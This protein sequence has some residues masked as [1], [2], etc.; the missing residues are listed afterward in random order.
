MI[1]PFANLGKW[2][3]L[4]RGCGALLFLAFLSAFAPGGN[5][6]DVP[7]AVRKAV[8]RRQEMVAKADEAALR[9]Q[10]MLADKDYA[11][12]VSEL[13]KALDLLPEAP[14]VESRRVEYTQQFADGSVLLARQRA[15]EGQYTEAMQIIE[16]V[17]DPAIDPENLEARR[18]LEDLND[19]EIYPQAITPEHIARVKRVE[20]AL[21]EASSHIRIG[22]YDGAERRYHEALNYD[23]YNSA[24]RR[25]L[26]DVEKHRRIYYDTAYDQTR[27]TFLRQVEEQWELKPPRF[28]VDPPGETAG[29]TLTQDGIGYINEK[30]KNIIIPEIEFAQTPFADAIEFL[31]EKS[32]EL[33]D[34]EPD[35]A[36]KGVNI[37]DPP[38]SGGAAAAP[39]APTGGVP[40][41][42]DPTAPAASMGG[43]AGST[44]LIDLK[45][46]QI[47]LVDALR[48][49]TE[50]ARL[51]FKVEPNA[52]KIIPLT[53]QN[54]DLATKV[55]RVPPSFLTAGASGGGGGGAQLSGDPFAN[56][57][58]TP[59]AGAA[60]LQPK[61]SAKEVLEGVGVT[62]PPDSSA[63]YNAT[64]SQLIVRNTQ[65][66]LDLVEAYVDS[67]KEDVQK[68]IFITSKFVEIG[69][70][71]D[72]TF[73]FD[74]L[75]GKANVP[76]SDRVFM[77]GG[78]IGS[79]RGQQQAQDWSFV[80]PIS[81]QP[82]GGDP[83][84]SGLRSGALA[85]NRN[86][87]DAL[88]TNTIA[89]QSTLAPAILSMAGVFTDPQ[90]Q[91]VLRAISQSKGTDLM[92]APSVVA[93]SGQIAKLEVIR[94]F[95]Y[96]TE[97]D[98]P[99]IPQQFGNQG[100][101]QQGGGIAPSVQSF[102]VTPAN[103]T[104]FETRNV[105]VT[106]QATPTIGPD[107]FTIDLRLEP[108][109]VEF[110]GFINYGSPIYTG[111]TA[112]G[113]PVQV[114]LTENRIEMPVFAKRSVATD[115]TI[116]DGQTVAVGG[117][118]REDIQHVEDKLPILGDLPVA[119]FLFRSKSEVHAKRN[120]TIFVTARLIDPSG[121][122]I[123]ESVDE[124]VAPV[125]IPG[126]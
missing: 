35:P 103:P 87:V 45:V 40:G 96:P 83:L 57:G 124:P 38:S 5:A 61:R 90:F 53:E 55:F 112:A 32:R 25:G 111:G 114:L 58:S 99:E 64:N 91:V 15:E 113:Q 110:E 17:L 71:N 74:W 118:I 67:L 116:W 37:I 119:G 2:Q 115:V 12:A 93:R 120:L 108:E 36:K 60:G 56:L 107:G 122:P 22:D 125:K 8:A 69:Q 101:G 34:L 105:G 28:S 84:T 47:P 1:R 76:G 29:P 62:F 80:E 85:V 43:G 11:G 16:A 117:L 66:N 109:V 97:Y 123:N 23:P 42:D 54:A 24:A 65:A 98:P 94:E 20:T 19:P 59:A 82:F 104:A 88:L 39:V 100:G 41:F 75:L 33:D 3:G 50:K 102:P 79:T 48:Y 51:K 95:I 49:V 13:K 44:T 6:Q 77:G 27:S 10:R 9:G 73:G 14:V 86:S 89:G 18:L 72:D 68:Q 52:V 46:T 63:I 81:Q 7:E 4:Q 121:A 26:E 30:L 126:S 106:L 70:D 78:T 31:R 21:K 92:S